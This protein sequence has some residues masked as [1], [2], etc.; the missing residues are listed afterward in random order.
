MRI[1][2]R[3]T[4][5]AIVRGGLV[6]LRGGNFLPP[7]SKMVLAGEAALTA[8]RDALDCRQ[9]GTRNPTEISEDRQPHLRGGVLAFV[10]G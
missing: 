6:R 1:A 7:L 3:A 5:A 4:A 8:A 2:R 10:R 9:W